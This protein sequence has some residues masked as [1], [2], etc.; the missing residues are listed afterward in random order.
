MLCELGGC[1]ERSWDS[2]K[3]LWEDVAIYSVPN[4]HSLKSQEHSC[5]FAVLE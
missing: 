2:V 5:D 4:S 3:C 1:F